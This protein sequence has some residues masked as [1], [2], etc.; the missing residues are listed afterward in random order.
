MLMREPGPKT[1]PTEASAG[2]IGPAKATLTEELGELL[3]E[4]QAP[5][6]AGLRETL[7]AE[8]ESKLRTYAS[9]ITMGRDRS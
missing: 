4:L 1:S 2:P 5:L 6:V 9:T 3:L 7:W 8:F